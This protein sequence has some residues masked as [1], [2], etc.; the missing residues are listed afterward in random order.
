MKQARGLPIDLERLAADLSAG[1]AR[2]HQMGNM[3]TYQWPLTHSCIFEHGASPFGEFNTHPQASLFTE[4]ERTRVQGEGYMK[5]VYAAQ[6]VRISDE[7]TYVD[8]AIGRGIRPNEGEFE[9]TVGLMTAD[10]MSRWASFLTN[11]RFAIHM[12]PTIAFR[13]QKTG[14]KQKGQAGR[15]GRGAQSSSNQAKRDV[16]VGV[17]EFFIRIQISYNGFNVDEVRMVTELRQALGVI[18]GGASCLAERGGSMFTYCLSV[19]DGFNDNFHMSHLAPP[20]NVTSIVHYVEEGKAIAQIVLAL[21]SACYHLHNILGLYMSRGFAYDNAGQPLGGVKHLDKLHIIW[22]GCNFM[23]VLGAHTLEQLLSPII[24]THERQK[25]HTR[26]EKDIGLAYLHEVNNLMILLNTGA[27]GKVHLKYQVPPPAP[28]LLRLPTSFGARRAPGQHDP[29]R[30]PVPPPAQAAVLETRSNYGEHN[31][32]NQMGGGG[33]GREP[34]QHDGG[35]GGGGGGGYQRAWHWAARPR[36]AFNAQELQHIAAAGGGGGVFYPRTPV[37]P[38]F[39]PA[40]I[41]QLNTGVRTEFPMTAWRGTPPSAGFNSSAL[42]DT[43][44]ID[45]LISAQV[46]REIEPLREQNALLHRE[47]AGLKQGLAGVNQ[48]VKETVISELADFKAFFSNLVKSSGGAAHDAS[49]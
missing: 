13:F 30:I 26:Q 29:T 40:V 31:Q 37:S 24:S 8:V 27:D 43:S 15:G 25:A 46:Q 39:S 48:T 2:T 41:T 3:C 33:Q 42:I 5:P 9:N 11:W 38:P 14:Q 23:G 12:F 1:T 32:F 34:K 45:R 47:V 6:A 16:L 4:I 17:K 19:E 35:A 20:T 28:I 21:E 10:V 18:P 49:A 36:A 22:K 7:D 44:H